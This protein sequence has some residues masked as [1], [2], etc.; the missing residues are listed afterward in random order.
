MAEEL[1]NVEQVE[2]APEAKAEG[3]K[4]FKK[5]R[6]DFKKKRFNKEKVDSEFD[7]KTI[8][9]RRVTK[10]VKGGKKM[11]FSVTSSRTGPAQ[12]SPS[13]P[14]APSCCGSS[15]TWPIRGSS[16]ASASSA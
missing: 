10:V 9:V 14:D 12:A 13:P 15:R 4:D 5:S 16:G 1:E 6:G 3:K 7:K 11:H 8:A 2:A